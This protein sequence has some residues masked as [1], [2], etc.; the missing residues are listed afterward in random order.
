MTLAKEFL[1]KNAELLKEKFN[2]NN[3]VG[4]AIIEC[5]AALD[6]FEKD[7]KLEFTDDEKNK[8][9]NEPQNIEQKQVEEQSTKQAEELLVKTQ[10]IVS[11]SITKPTIQVLKL[12]SCGYKGE[13]SSN[14]MGVSDWNL[15]FDTL[16]SSEYDNK[17]SSVPSDGTYDK[18]TFTAMW[19]DNAPFDFYREERVDIG[20]NDYNPFMS[21]NIFLDEIISWF[22]YR[23]AIYICGAGNYG[24][25]T[26][27]YTFEQRLLINAFCISK[28]EW[29]YGK[30][31]S[32]SYKIINACRKALA[33]RDLDEIN[34]M[35]KSLGLSDLDKKPYLA[36]D[37]IIGSLRPFF[38]PEW[39]HMV[40]EGVETDIVKV[41]KLYIE[42]GAENADDY[43]YKYAK[44][45]PFLATGF[46]ESFAPEVK[47]VQ[48]PQ[49]TPPQVT[50]P[51]PTVVNA[52]IVPTPEKDEEPKLNEDE[53][54]KNIANLLTEDELKRLEELEQGEVEEY[55]D[56]DIDIED[57]DLD[58]L[59]DLE[60]DD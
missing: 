5:L 49:P 1:D 42:Q 33:A 48:T 31:N 35:R 45:L 30:G 59:D 58:D 16:K 14:V 22:A 21:D 8:L 17:A 37:S 38:E 40:F 23:W 28:L 3:A 11:Q 50:M 29:N 15:L 53:E 46:V 56:I 12:V 7:N 25:N 27:D 57:I 13:V 36:E 44:D 55:E 6:Y 39:M 10:Q 9:I 2:E 20:L 47:S 26:D 34:S 51:S 19:G 32:P 18:V 52:A 54:L 43:M 24:F 41:S 4:N 60:I